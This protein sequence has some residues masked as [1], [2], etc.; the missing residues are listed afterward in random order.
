MCVVCAWQ[1]E[2]EEGEGEG[3]EDPTKDA[4]K[5]V[6]SSRLTHLVSSHLVSPPLISPRLILSRRFSSCL[7]ACLATW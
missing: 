5:G 4:I 3:E 2:E 6:S 1:E 7:A